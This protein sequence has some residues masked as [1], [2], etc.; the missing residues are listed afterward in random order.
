ML[1]GIS[2]GTR[3]LALGVALAGMVIANSCTPRETNVV[4]SYRPKRLSASEERRIMDAV[5]KYLREERP[6][7]G[8]D[9]NYLRK[10]PHVIFDHRTFWFVSFEFPE[11]RVGQLGGFPILHVDKKTLKVILSYHE[12]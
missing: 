7:W 10:L 2:M 1:E 4:G 3:S 5:Y 8:D 6:D 9:P 11:N 12:Q